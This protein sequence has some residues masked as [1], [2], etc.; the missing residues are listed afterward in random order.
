MTLSGAEVAEPG[1]ASHTVHVRG[2][3]LHYLEWG[4]PAGPALVLLHGGGQSAF[5]WQRVAAYFAPRYRLIAPD[6]RGHGDSDWAA[7][8]AYALDDLREDLHELAVQ[9]G[10]GAFVLAGMS[11]GGMTALS[12]GG[13]YGH[14]LRGLVVVDIAPEIQPEGRER[15][16]G[17]MRGRE[18]F[19]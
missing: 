12:Y 10:L 2:L 14:T 5:T 6:A 3:D 8:G 16:V 4:A 9:L 17:F 18:A 19:A 1:P 11:L 7:D 13:V 15:I